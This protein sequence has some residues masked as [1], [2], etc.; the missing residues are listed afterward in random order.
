MDRD[1]LLVT[2]SLLTWGLGE[3]LFIYFQPIY[4]QQLGADPI[5]IGAIL[6]GMGITMT[7]VHI[8]AGLVSDRFGRRPIMWLSWVLGALAIWMMALANSLFLFVVG[9][10]IYG[11]TSFVSAPMN[12]YIAGARG[13][14]SVGRALTLVQGMYSL[15]AVAGPFLGDSLARRWVLEPFMSSRALSS[16]SQ[17]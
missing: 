16:W 17:P 8:P 4:L 7:V 14:W 13:K 10:W 15:G 6:G 1:L 2:I 12:S 3:G 11:L 5:A 9:V